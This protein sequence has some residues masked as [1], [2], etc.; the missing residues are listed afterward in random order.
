MFTARGLW[1]L[2]L[3][4]VMTGIAPDPASADRVTL[5]AGGGTAEEGR[6]TECKLVEPFACGL[7][8]SGTLYITEIAGRVL[9]VDRS[10]NLRRVAGK[11]GEGDAGDGGPASSAELNAPHHMLVLPSGDVLVADT[12]NRR[13][14]KIVAESGKIVPF[15]GTGQAGDSGDGGPALNGK[16]GAIYCL[17]LDSRRNAIYLCDLDNR[18]IRKIDLRSG[19]VS[20]VA[21]N[22]KRGTPDD[23]ALAVQSPLQDPRAIAVDSKGSLY[24]L[25][26]GGNA[27]R[28]VDTKGR[29]TTIVGTGKAGPPGDGNGIS[30]TL[31]GPKHLAVDRDDNVLIADTDNHVIRKYTVGDG[32]IVTIAGTGATG[33]GGVGGPPAD[34]QLNQPHGVYVDRRG[35][36]YICDS[37]NH[38]VLRIDR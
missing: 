7:D 20:T 19:I 25:E 2:L 26:R 22:G 31:R 38:R 10:G 8:R 17:A 27:L 3:T 12:M 14:R 9:A 29:I 28:V 37:L 1:I 11:L 23:G 35:T 24:I 36:I 5:I 6:A 21:G 13:V 18:R 30:A 4:N 15:A 16:F 34:L 33:T 32:K